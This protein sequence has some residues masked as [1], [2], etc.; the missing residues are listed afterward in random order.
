MVDFLSV[1]IWEGR[2]IPFPAA[3]VQEE[4]FERRYSIDFCKSVSSPELHFFP[5]KDSRD[6]HPALIIAPGGGYEFL[7]WDLE[8]TEIAG[9]FNEAG[10]SVFVLKYR[11]PDQRDAAHADAVRAV[12]YVRANAAKFNIDPSRVGMMGFSA[13]AHLTA[14][15]CAPAE[16]I[17]Y[18]AVDNIDAF[19][20][21][22][23]FAALI[24]P[25]YLAD[26]DLKL[27]K[28]F[29]ASADMPPVFLCQ[30]ED[31][32]VRVEN[33]LAW[34]FA[35]KKNGVSAELHIFAE[36]GHGYGSRPRGLPVDKWHGECT[37]WMREQA[38]F[39]D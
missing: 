23:D 12:R 30:A 27:N 31:D 25:A 19:S 39:K 2:D 6:I 37:R 35:A 11:C 29:R 18:E 3:E 8:G 26:D 9:I 7:S 32:A 4:F 21:R 15:L 1:K 36:G 38:G 17:A 24:Y 34:F 13:G 28:E 22:P 33:S 10:F 16:E 14:T 20:Y 5:R